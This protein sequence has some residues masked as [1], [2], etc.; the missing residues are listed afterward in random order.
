MT[1]GEA[2][3]D[4]AR[5][6]EV[7]DLPGW[8]RDLTIESPA[9]GKVMVRLLLPSTYDQQPSA[10]FP[11]LYLLHGASGE[12]TDWTL[13]TDVEAMTRPTDLLVVMPAGRQLCDSDGWYTDWV[14]RGNRPN[15]TTRRC[16]RRST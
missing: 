8:M 16:G 9:V 11:V 7:K 2:A 12:Y 14:A 15:S 4:G 3:D 10:T 5:I 6:L 1:I 13:N